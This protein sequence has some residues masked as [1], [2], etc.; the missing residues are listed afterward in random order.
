MVFSDS[1]IEAALSA[2]TYLSVQTSTQAGTTPPTNTSANLLHDSSSRRQGNFTLFAAMAQLQVAKDEA[3]YGVALTDAYKAQA[4][5][6][7]VMYLYEKKFKDHRATS[8]SSG[9]ES[10]S[11]P[12]NGAMEDYKEV[13]RTFEAGSIDSSIQTHADVDDYPEEWKNTQLTPE[14]IAIKE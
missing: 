7:Y 5:A 2:Y 10:I 12:V 1:D 4:C 9:G 11:R 13:F 6:Y 14:E 8:I 3:L